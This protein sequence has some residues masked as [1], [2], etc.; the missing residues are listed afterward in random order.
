MMLQMPVKCSDCKKL[1][2]DVEEVEYYWGSKAWLCEHCRKLKK[3]E[4][5]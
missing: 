4:R 3:W 1:T 5:K 2:T